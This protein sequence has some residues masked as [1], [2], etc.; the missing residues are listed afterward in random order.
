MGFLMNISIEIVRQLV[1]RLVGMY[2][3]M[4]RETFLTILPD[5]WNLRIYEIKQRIFVSFSSIYLEFTLRGIYSLEYSCVAVDYI[6][7]GYASNA[8]V[9]RLIQC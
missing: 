5:T 2:T 4:Q 9:N 7:A 6:M 8:R 1:V 3:C